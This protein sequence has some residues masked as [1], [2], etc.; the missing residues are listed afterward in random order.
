MIYFHLCLYCMTFWWVDGNDEN[1]PSRCVLIYRHN[2]KE[3]R[4]RTTARPSRQSW[5][6]GFL[7]SKTWTKSLFNY[8]KAFVLTQELLWLMKL[9]QR[10]P[11]FVRPLKWYFLSCWTFWF[12]L[13]NFQGLN[14]RCDF[15]LCLWLSF[16][17]VWLFV[18]GTIL[19]YDSLVNVAN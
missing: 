2:N 3:G 1:D 14:T 6:L 16:W 13:R 11:L 8:M 15:S 12:T 17:R 4:K 5:I 10:R 9:R 18:R 19:V 7:C